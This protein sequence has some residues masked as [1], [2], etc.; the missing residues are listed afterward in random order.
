[1]TATRYLD[2]PD[3]RVAY[4]VSGEGLLIVCL[5]G[6]GELRSAFRFT[7]PALTAAGY[8][9]ATMDLRGH[10]DSDATF[11][12]YDDVAA[13]QDALALIEHLGGPAVVIGNSMGAGAAVWAA[14]ERPESVSALV[15]IGPFVRNPPAHP[16][17]RALLRV[18]MARPWARWVWKA[19]YPSLTPGRKPTD[20]TAHRRSIADSMRRPGRAR[21]FSATTRT[22]H[23]PAE[24]RLPRVPQPALVVMGTLDPD[25]PDP[26][27]EARWVADQLRAD[28]LLV[29][30]S[31]H[32]PQADS[33]EIVNERV[34]DF[35]RSVLA[36]A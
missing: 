3:G 11:S 17:V 21:A 26:A 12:R 31:G 8:R 30:G 28:V 23:A 14:A 24:E 13:G 32:Y 5:P 16:A 36:G 10:G 19:Y 7:V 33:P 4:D 35:C 18:L 9:V 1:M 25:F 22:S 29:P 2:R 15:L 27:A 20:F 6:M 34:V